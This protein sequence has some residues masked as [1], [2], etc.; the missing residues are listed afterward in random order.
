MPLIILTREATNEILD[1][2]ANIGPEAARELA[3]KYGIKPTYVKK[4]ACE[5]G[6]RAKRKPKIQSQRDRRW[7]LAIQRGAVLA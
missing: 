2:Y 1:T 4:L 7:Q 3:P 6:V 5:H